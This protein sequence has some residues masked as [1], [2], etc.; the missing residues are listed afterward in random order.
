MNL[1]IYCSALI[2]SIRMFDSIKSL[3]RCGSK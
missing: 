1:V 2:Y 3:M